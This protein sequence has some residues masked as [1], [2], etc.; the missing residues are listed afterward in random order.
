[1]RNLAVGPRCKTLFT[2]ICLQLGPSWSFFKK[3]YMTITFSNMVYWLFGARITSPG[4]R[5]TPSCRKLF[6]FS[7]VWTAFYVIGRPR[8]LKLK[9]KMKMK[10]L[11]V[12]L[13]SHH[14]YIGDCA[15]WNRPSL[16]FYEL[17]IEKG[18]HLNRGHTFDFS[19]S[20]NFE[21]ERIQPVTSNRQKPRGFLS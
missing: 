8:P 7:Y 5:Q 18:R 4:D 17:Y 21:T 15:I 19:I 11:T 14:S 10:T 2:R 12:S 13:N 16:A 9:E 6:L 3:S 1:M 20:I